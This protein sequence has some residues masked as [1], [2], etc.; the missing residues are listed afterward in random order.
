MN[1]LPFPQLKP[2][3]E[4]DL[5][6]L[7]YAGGSSAVFREWDAIFPDWV[8]LRP[9]ELPGR[10]TLMGTPLAEDPVQLAQQLSNE[11]AK[12]IQRPWAIFGH[13]LGAALAYRITHLMNSVHPLVGFFPSG[14]HSPT[15]A[16]PAPPRS[17]LSDEDLIEEVRALNGSPRELLENQELMALLLPIIR[18]DFHLNERISVLP[19]LGPVTCDMY[20]F[21]STHDPEVPVA[22]LQHWQ[23]VAGAEFRQQVLPGDH[24]FLHHVS[25][26]ELMRDAICDVLS[27][28]VTLTG[29]DCAIHL[30][31]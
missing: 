4:V 7:P 15:C 19:S 10:G 5:F 25:Q 31:Q 8:S 23:D 13:S 3:A 21:G 27:D 24:F 6:C 30:G 26:R 1:C 17:H 28:V 2:A 20:V 9:L 29:S 12:H 14:R 18:A 11:L 16:D 22:E